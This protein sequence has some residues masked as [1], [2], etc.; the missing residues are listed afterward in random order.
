MKTRREADRIKVVL[1][2]KGWTAVA[3]AEAL[4]LDEGTCGATGSER[5]IE[6][7]GNDGYAGRF[8]Y[9]NEMQRQVL[10]AHLRSTCTSRFRRS[11]PM[12]RSALASPQVRLQEAQGGPG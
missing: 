2:G 4:L 11:R 8:G 10:E 9:L 5:G 3:V 6:A 7:L 12:C 1:L